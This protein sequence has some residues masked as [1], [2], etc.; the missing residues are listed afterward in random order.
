[1][2]NTIRHGDSG[3]L[4]QAAKLLTGCAGDAEDFDAEYRSHVVAWQGAHNLTADGVIGSKTWTAIAQAAPTCSTSRN[5]DSAATRALQLI[6][7]G[8][9]TADGIFGPRT[10][11]AVAAFQ[12]AKG[13][14]AD[15]ICGPKT[16]AALITGDA[17]QPGK[18]VQPV[19][20]KQYDSRWASKMYSSHNDSGQTMRNSG[21][22]PTAMADIVATL[23]APGTTPYDLAKLSMEWG[24]RTYSSGTSWDFF[25]KIAAH[26]KFSRM[27]Q[28][29]SLETL[30]ACLDAGGYAVCSMGPDYWT[31]GGHFICAWKYDDTDI[32]CNDPA[33]AKRTHQNQ[34]DFMKQ[35]K[36]FFC[37]Y[38]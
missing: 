8:N 28:T 14:V 13:L 6:L 24:T 7:D 32:Y 20:Y 26:Y 38:K 21:C 4:V 31:K 25:G 5:R 36:Q 37:F 19:D 10:K 12:A 17:A 18:F 11:A 35:R 29:A 33:S 15:G 2:L 34:T 1:M 23:K 16:W 27:I 22:G 3:K 9:L 30:K